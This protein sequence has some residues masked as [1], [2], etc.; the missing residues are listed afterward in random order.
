MDENGSEALK[1]YSRG[2]M[3]ALDLRRRLG[4]ISYGEVLQLLSEASLPLPRAPVAGREAQLLQAREW[5]FPKHG[6]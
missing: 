3:T 6:A 1:A 5:M 2:A 4:N